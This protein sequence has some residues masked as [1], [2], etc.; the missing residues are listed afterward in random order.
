MHRDDRFW[1]GSDAWR[2]RQWRDTSPQAKG[3]AYVPFGAGPR[4]CLGQRFALLETTLVLA[5][6][7]Q[8]YHLAPTCDLVLDPEMPLQPAHS[9]PARVHNRG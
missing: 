5:T 7:G 4:I 6:I 9:V 3:Y 2:P 1:D 8:Q